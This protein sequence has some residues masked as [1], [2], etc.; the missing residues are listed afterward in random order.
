MLLSVHLDFLI[1]MSGFSSSD[2]IYHLLLKPSRCYSS[3]YLQML[4]VLG[5]QVKSPGLPAADFSLPGTPWDPGPPANSRGSCGTCT[6]CPLLTLDRDGGGNELEA[7]RS[8]GGSA[9]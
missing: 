3:L 1:F 5:P 8:R 4:L 2:T 7:G 9:R 6:F